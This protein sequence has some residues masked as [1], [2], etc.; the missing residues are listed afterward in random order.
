MTETSDFGSSKRESHDS[1]KFYDRFEEFKPDKTGKPVDFPASL[2]N[3]IFVHSSEHMTEIPDNS[4]ALM[5]TSPPYNAGKTCDDDL[6]FDEYLDMLV[7]VMT[8]TYRVLE[9]GGRAAINIAG[10][11]RSPYIPMST[12]I[13]AIATEIGF[14]PR[15]HIVWE[16]AEGA[17]GSCAWGSFMSASNP[18]LRDLH[19]YILVFSKDRFDRSKSGKS[20]ISKADFMAW[21]LSIWKMR[22]ESAK[23]IG[24]PAPFPVELPHRLIQLYTYEGDT[25][26]DPFMGSGTTGVA[27]KKLGRHYVG[28]D[29]KQ[30][31]ADLAQKRIDGI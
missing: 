16:K 29:N 14:L 1:K 6:T 5:V 3:Q 18:T 7:N 22:P 8:E 9:P 25:V 26:L 2:R 28:Y 12:Y 10:L 27:A 23:K 30:E 31:W 20:T 4:V 11:G 17:S 13:D 24:H 15:G 19:E 21:T